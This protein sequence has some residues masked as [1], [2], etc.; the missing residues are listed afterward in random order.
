MKCTYLQCNSAAMP[1][2]TNASVDVTVTVTSKRTIEANRSNTLWLIKYQFVN[3]PRKYLLDRNT[4][5]ENEL[6][7]IPE[8]TLLIRE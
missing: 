4:I 7:K 6:S 2:P 8:R 3:F 5:K 1:K